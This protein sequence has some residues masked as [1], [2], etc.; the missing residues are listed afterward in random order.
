LDAEGSLG[1]VAAYQSLVSEGFLIGPIAVARP[2]R[3][4]GGGWAIEALTTAL[5][6]MTAEADAEGYSAVRVA[7]KIHEDNRPSQRLFEGQRFEQTSVRA[8]GYQV[9]SA[10]FPIE[11]TLPFET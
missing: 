2:Y 11:G 3:H 9:W 10:E 1:G 4:R 7:A 5:D 8:D 6:F